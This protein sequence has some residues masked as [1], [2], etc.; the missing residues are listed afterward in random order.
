MAFHIFNLSARI[1]LADPRFRM[2]KCENE[3]YIICLFVSLMSCGLATPKKKS[4]KKNKK[5]MSLGETCT[6]QSQQFIFYIFILPKSRGCHS[7]KHIA[8]L[9]TAQQKCLHIYKFF[10]QHSGYFLCH[11]WP[12]CWRL[13]YTFKLTHYVYV[14]DANTNAQSHGPRTFT[15]R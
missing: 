9:I 6:A 5:N 3:I 14:L 15:H 1:C 2:A 4:K 7:S 12:S 11:L 10:C 13:A 8:N